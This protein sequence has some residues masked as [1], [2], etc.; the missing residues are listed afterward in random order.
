MSLPAKKRLRLDIE[1]D[2]V[3][4][5][6]VDEDE[7]TPGNV[8]FYCDGANLYYVA[9]CSVSYGKRKKDGNRLSD[10]ALLYITFRCALPSFVAYNRA[11]VCS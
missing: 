5:F 7:C 9:G 11:F 6:D 3:S 10:I 4:A 2:A 1:S 8:K